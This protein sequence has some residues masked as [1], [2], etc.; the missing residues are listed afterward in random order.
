[1]PRTAEP[2]GTTMGDVGWSSLSQPVSQTKTYAGHGLVQVPGY[3]RS[4]KGVAKMKPPKW[5]G[6][7]IWFQLVGKCNVQVTHLALGDSKTLV[8]SVPG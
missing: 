5:V 6:V 8:R 1:M 7:R 4:P 2:T 3:G